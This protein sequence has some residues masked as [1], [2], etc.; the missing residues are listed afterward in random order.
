MQQGGIAQTND[1]VAIVSTAL[2]G[3]LPSTA[4][5]L[6]TATIPGQTRGA[7]GAAAAGELVA[8]NATH[9]ELTPLVQQKAAAAAVR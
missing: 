1:S 9:Y 7:D 4:G 2:P 3:I 6:K 5:L 8:G